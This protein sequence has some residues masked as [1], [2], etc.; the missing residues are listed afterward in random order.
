[1]LPKS[2]KRDSLA[3][4]LLLIV[5]TLTLTFSTLVLLARSN[6]LPFLT[7][8]ISQVQWSACPIP[9][10]PAPYPALYPKAFHPSQ[11]LR[12]KS[13]SGAS[14]IASDD[15]ID[16][17]SLLLPPNGGFLKV[18]EANGETKGY[19]VSMFHQ[20]HCLTMMRT[21]LLGQ[22]MSM[23]HETQGEE[24]KKDPRH[25]V[26]CLEYLTQVR[27]PPPPQ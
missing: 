3:Q 15:D 21:M 19:G 5:F 12:P 20:L 22:A 16:W 7:P 9:P 17:Q 2:P 6:H 4:A 13:Y 8:L 11:Q 14:D 24:W 27:S 18:E 1:M 25:W 23:E 26:H 10:S